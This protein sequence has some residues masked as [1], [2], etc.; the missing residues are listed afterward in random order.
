MAEAADELEEYLVPDLTIKQLLDSIPA[1][2]LA[3]CDSPI[4]T[5]LGVPIY[6]LLGWPAYVLNN[7]ERQRRYPKGTNHF[8]PNSILLSPHQRN[9]VLSNINVALWPSGLF[10]AIYAYGFATQHPQPVSW[11]ELTLDKVNHWLVL[12]TFL[13]HTD[14]LVPHYRAPEFTSPR[15]VHT[16]LDRRLLRDLGNP[17]QLLTFITCHAD[18]LADLA[19]PRRM[20]CTTYTARFRTTTRAQEPTTLFLDSQN[21]YP[22]VRPRSALRQH[23]VFLCHSESLTDSQ[24]A[25]KSTRLLRLVEQRRQHTIAAQ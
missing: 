18:A 22:R 1:L 17:L 2:W 6:L 9:S 12:I 7:V 5:A 8:N 11:N 24:T 14:P 21:H 19:S 13:Q 20:L 10:A 16:T 4:C 3:M 25:G 23:S 15:G